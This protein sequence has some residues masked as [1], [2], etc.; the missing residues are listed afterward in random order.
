MRALGLGMVLGAVA[1]GSDPRDG[2]KSTEEQADEFVWNIPVGLVEPAVPEDNPMTDAK[3]E[4]GRHLFYDNRLSVNEETSCGS[5]HL[6]SLAFTDGLGQAVGTT[7]EVHRRSAMSLV[8]V[9][10]N[11]SYT[12]ANNLLTDLEHQALGPLFGTNPVELGL[13]D[14][15]QERLDRFAE[16]SQYQVLFA[17]AFPEEDDP[18]TLDATLKAIAS[19]QRTI[20]VGDSDYDRYFAG[21]PG[22]M[23][24]AAKDGAALFF[25]ERL[26]CYH[27]HGGFNFTDAS[28][29]ADTPFV[30]MAF[31]VNALYNVDGN[32]A[33]PL[34]DQG[35]I[36]VTGDARD[37]GAFKAPTLRNVTLTAPY[38]HD[39]SVADLDAVLDHYAAAGR[40]IESGEDAGVGADNPFK[41]PFLVGFELTESERAAM[42][43]LF[44]AITNED[45]LYD[46]RFADPFGN[47][48]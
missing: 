5:C 16:D 26:E 29:H 34:R 21:D 43:A 44:D 7:G 28:A 39:G 8:N 40:T 15:E 25:S 38:M 45:A 42:H 32:G 18:Y 11:T 17:E 4:L 10:Y 24:D 36:E 3:V 19:F 30:E 1:C 47:I 41:S 31:H 22:A 2:V 35:L 14:L 46:E 12:W 13:A 27:C 20:L 48:E 6:P 33:Y 23:S 9:A 37:M